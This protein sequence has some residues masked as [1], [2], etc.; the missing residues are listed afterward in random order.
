MDPGS[1]YMASLA[2]TRWGSFWKAAEHPEQPQ[3]W[4]T[5]PWYSTG[6][7]TAAGFSAKQPGQTTTSRICAR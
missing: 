1:S 2:S 4:R 7:M 3:K 5:V 6:T